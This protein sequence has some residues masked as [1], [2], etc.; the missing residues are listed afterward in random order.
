MNLFYLNLIYC[1][2]IYPKEHLNQVNVKVLVENNYKQMY[3][4]MCKN[5]DFNASYIFMSQIK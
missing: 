2:I 3:F 1:N 4:T 5:W